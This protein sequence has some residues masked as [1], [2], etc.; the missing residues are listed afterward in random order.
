MDRQREQI[1]ICV[2]AT[3][4]GLS[5]PS[6][7]G[8]HRGSINFGYSDDGSCLLFSSPL[9][10]QAYSDGRCVGRRVVGCIFQKTDLHSFYSL[11][12]FSP[13]YCIPG[14]Y[15]SWIMDGIRLETRQDAITH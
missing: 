6:P 7:T 14:N 11:Q 3:G 9:H 4:N 1:N 2:H 10:M 12:T 13:L 8:G 15:P 5:M